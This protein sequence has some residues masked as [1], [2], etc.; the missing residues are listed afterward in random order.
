MVGNG[1]L[2]ISRVSA[3]KQEAQRPQRKTARQV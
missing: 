2:A 3:I 1:K